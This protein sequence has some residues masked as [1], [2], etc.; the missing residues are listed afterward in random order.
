MHHLLHAHEMLASV[1]LEMHNTHWW[2][3][4]FEGMRDAISVQQLPEYVAWFRR[5]RS[6]ARGLEQ[7]GA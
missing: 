4:F 7:A 3:G 1:L 5:R 6:A 2:L